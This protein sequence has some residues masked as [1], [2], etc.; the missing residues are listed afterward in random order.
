L[1]YEY[2]RLFGSRDL[3]RLL[4]FTEEGEVYTMVYN[5]SL[6][7]PNDIEIGLSGDGGW[8]KTDIPA[9][10][11]KREI[12]VTDTW[13]S[14]INPRLETRM[15]CGASRAITIYQIKLFKGPLPCLN[16]YVENGL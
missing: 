9:N 6:N 13:K 10:S 16:D 1:E 3:R 11:D 14:V 5:V 15:S 2:G 12:A 7:C 4:E 8:F